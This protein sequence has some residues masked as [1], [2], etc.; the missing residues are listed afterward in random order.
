MVGAGPGGQEWGVEAIALGLRDRKKTAPASEQAMLDAELK[1][2]EIFAKQLPKPKVA[3]PTANLKQD[4]KELQNLQTYQQTGRMPDKDGKK[5]VAVSPEE[6]QKLIDTQKKKIQEDR[7]SFSPG[8]DLSN[9]QYGTLG[10]WA[11]VDYGMEL[12]NVY[13][14]RTDRFWRLMQLEDGGWCYDAHELAR[15]DGK[16]DGVDGDCGDRQS[17]CVPGICGHGTAAD[18]QAGQ[19]H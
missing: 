18:S 2:L 3:D 7:T 15:T 5:M 12:P 11:L 4:E 17:F 6:I 10:A 9:G 19:E 16:T 14:T 8:G 13:W 1:E